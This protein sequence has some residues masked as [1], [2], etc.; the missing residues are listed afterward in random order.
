MLLD[1]KIL[2]PVE[3][4]CGNSSG[5]VLEETRVKMIDVVLKPHTCKVFFSGRKKRRKISLL[6]WHFELTNG[7]LRAFE[8]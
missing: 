8:S 6:M 3:M 2:D 4:R 5:L 7:L 1:S